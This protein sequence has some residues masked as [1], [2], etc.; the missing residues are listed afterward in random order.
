MKG[1]Q[2]L[3]SDQALMMCKNWRK[4]SPK[5]GCQSAKNLKLDIQ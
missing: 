3:L 2:F 5:L 1:E 4:A